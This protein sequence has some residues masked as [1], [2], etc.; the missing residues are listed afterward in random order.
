VKV[1]FLD[2]DGV[3]NKYPGDKNYVTKWSEFKFIPGSIEGIR[4]LNSCGFKLVLIS[5]QAGVGKGLYSQKALDVMTKKMLNQLKKAKA[6]LDRIYYCTHSPVDNC[7]CRKPKT[8]LLK[9]AIASLGQAPSEMYFIGDS[10]LDMETAI[11]FSA[12]PILVLSGR[13]KIVN[14]PDWK[15]EPD[16]IFDNL[17]VAANYLCNLL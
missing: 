13:E 12:K 14:R 2:R 4:K 9:K 10:F 16:Y 7:D 1:V 17:L 6:G 3:I 8:A 15:F 5:N 11:N